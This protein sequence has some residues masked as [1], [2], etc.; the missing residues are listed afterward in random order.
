MNST[1]ADNPKLTRRLKRA[2]LI[3]LTAV[4]ILATLA[5]AIFAYLEASDNQDESLLSVAQLVESNQM[6]AAADDEIFDDDHYDDS[7][8]R[9]WELGRKHRR[10]ISFKKKINPGFHTV[11]E[12]DE[13]WRVYVTEKNNAGKQFIVAQQLSVSAELALNSAKNTAMPLLLLFLV[14]PLLVTWIVRHS[15]K[16]IDVLADK[17]QRSNSLQLE[18]EDQ[19]EIPVELVPFVSA[20]DTLLEK[21]ESYNQRQRRFI[22]DAA[23]E[24]RTPIAAL[25]LQ[26]DNVQSA[27]DEHSKRERQ[28]ALTKSIHRLQRLVNQLLDLARAQSGLARRETF[29]S[30]NEQVKSQISELYPLA[31]QK[32]LE[33]SVSR[34]EPT[35]VMDN[36]NQLQHLIR[37]ALSNAIKFTP[38]NGTV[39]IAL[40]KEGQ[41]AVFKVTDSGPGVP[42]EQLEKL[43][44]PFYRSDEQASGYGAGLGL[45]ICHEIAALLN[46]I[47]TLENTQPSGF[48]FSYR[49][50]V[51]ESDQLSDG[52]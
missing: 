8:I 23:H 51:V 12:D 38:E 16:P 2:L 31:D 32:N 43:H 15:F 44:Q 49:Q 25:T 52:S 18:I 14:I 40:Y 27:P 47:I 36:N 28:S 29:V 17:L 6:S 21:N 11:H 9:V 5:A 48:V 39:D 1:K 3:T 10:S 33:L 26:I 24:L 42:P 13:F 19:R 22:A 30:L 20:I 50:N 45:A 34:N 35:H 46:G 37:N 4:L 7:A 41:Q